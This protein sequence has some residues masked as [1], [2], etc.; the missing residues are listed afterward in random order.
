MVASCQD[1]FMELGFSTHPLWAPGLILSL[2]AC[3]AAA[4]STEC[5]AGLNYTYHYV[6]LL[7]YST[8]KQGSPREKPQV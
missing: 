3:A 5:L 1:N 6:C 8:K 7:G 2:Q 4:P